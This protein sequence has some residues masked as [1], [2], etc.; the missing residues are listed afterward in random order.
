MNA[1]NDADEI[2]IIKKIVQQSWLTKPLLNEL[3]QVQSSRSDI[4]GEASLHNKESFDEKFG[5]VF[6]MDRIWSSEVQ[7]YQAATLLLE[8]WYYKPTMNSI[9]KNII[10]VSHRSKKEH[11]Y[12]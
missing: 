3:E 7:F 4:S 10:T 9:F 1:H 8:K 2:S 11:Y 5:F 12:N 6:F